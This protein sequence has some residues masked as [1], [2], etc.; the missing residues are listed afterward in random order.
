MTT[1]AAID[2]IEQRTPYIPEGFRY[3]NKPEST[4]VYDVLGGRLHVF[5]GSDFRKNQSLLME[6]AVR[7]DQ[8]AFEIGYW[9]SMTEVAF[10]MRKEAAAS[11]TFFEPD[12][13]LQVR[14]PKTSP[15]RGKGRVWFSAFSRLTTPV[16]DLF[17]SRTEAEYTWD[18][19]FA[20]YST[21]E[22]WRQVT[23]SGV[24]TG[25]YISTMAFVPG[26]TGLKI[27]SCVMRHIFN[28][29]K[30][31]VVLGRVQNGAPVSAMDKARITEGPIFG[32]DEEPDPMMRSWI[33]FFEDRTLHPNGIDIDKLIARGVYPE[34]EN[35][36]Y[37]HGRTSKE[38]GPAHGRASEATMKLRQ[39]GVVAK[40]GDGAYIAAWRRGRKEPWEMNRKRLFM[41]PALIT[42][43]P[44][45]T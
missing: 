14:L 3:L 43:T 38:D 37:E 15:T 44:G 35:R 11:A 21:E 39:R 16:T 34:G 2:R 19:P 25:V 7:I 20:G 42:S 1:G 26:L 5:M 31:D 45:I 6:Y 17:N 41:V 32:V 4:I 27:G 30:S 10:N 40:K 18:L 24:L 13:S 9:P 28:T 29:H 12:E 8:A 22:T 23:G 33:P 36:T